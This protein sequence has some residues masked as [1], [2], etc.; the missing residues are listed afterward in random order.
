MTSLAGLD[1]A[2]LWMYAPITETLRAGLAS[3]FPRQSLRSGNR[4]ACDPFG[5]P[6]RGL[7]E[8]T[9]QTS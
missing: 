2:Y 3:R 1:V 5:Q 7:L 9:S 8:K 4:Q 6:E